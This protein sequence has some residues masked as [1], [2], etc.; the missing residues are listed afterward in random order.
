MTNIIFLGAPGSGKGTQSTLLAENLKI[1]N[2]ST[3]EILRKEVAN[4]S[5]IGNLAKSYMES[6]GLV[7]DKIVVDIIKKRISKVDCNNGFILDGFPRNLKQA[8]ILEQMLIDVGK[9]INLVVNIEADEDILVKRISGRFTCKKCGTVYNHFFKQTKLA[10]ICD[11]CSSM[12]F[13]SR[14]DDNEETVRNRLKVYN[15]N[16]QELIEFYRKKDL[17]YSVNGLKNITLV[18]LDI[19]ERVGVLLNNN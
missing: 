4:E 6:G 12:D 17:I 10:N 19:N 16:T 11:K 15:Q 1:P 14:I 13:E 9:K 18:N 5:E 3:G 7:P 8:Q 2:I